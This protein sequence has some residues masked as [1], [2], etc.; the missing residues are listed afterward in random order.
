MASNKTLAAQK[1]QLVLEEEELP[2]IW[3]N[4]FSIEAAQEFIKRLIQLDSNPD[5]KD[6]FV[7]ITS[8]GGEAYSLLAMIEAMYACQTPIHTVGLGLCASAGGVLLACSPGT[9]W[10]GKNTFLHIHHL[11]TGIIGDLPSVKNDIEHSKVLEK[12]IFDLL[13]AKSKMSKEE[14]SK[15][16]SKKQKEWHLTATEAK[17]LGFVDRIGLPVF[18]KYTTIEYK[19]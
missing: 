14:L 13:L 1:T 4:E 19:G 16:L 2:I 12:K 7:Y 11:Q 5:I 15:V 10:I 17:K 18:K 8:F 3:V 6:I 9:R